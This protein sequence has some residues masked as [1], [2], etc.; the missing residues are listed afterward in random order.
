MAPKVYL[1]DEV[2]LRIDEDGRAILTIGPPLKAAPWREAKKEAD[3]AWFSKQATRALE[4]LKRRE[5]SEV[6]LA[7]KRSLLTVGGGFA[8]VEGKNV[9]LVR[10]SPDAPVVPNL[11]DICAGAFDERWGSLVEML[12]GEAVEV[13]RFLPDSNEVIVPVP[14]RLLKPSSRSAVRE[15]YVKAS[16]AVL[17]KEKAEEVSFREVRSL[18]IEPEQPVRVIYEDE[19]SPSLAVLF[20]VEC[21]SVELVGLMD[22]PALP[23]VAYSD[24]EY[25]ETPEGP[26]ALNREVHVINAESLS[27]TV[28]KK[29]KVVRQGY[30]TDILREMS[31]T[32]DL[33]RALTGKALLALENLPFGRLR[34][35][36]G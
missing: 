2:V 5:P 10:R 25:V 33:K 8:Q 28:W 30:F 26:R 9:I 20:D 32:D 21:C 31:G 29:F 17:G 11:L 14:E 36:F 24:G 3:K 19:E 6:E 22:V 27:D 1:F 4:A 15:E 23:G 34:S 7:S 16:E 13:F 35:L 18:L 12:A